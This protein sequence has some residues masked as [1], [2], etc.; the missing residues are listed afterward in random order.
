MPIKTY[1]CKESTSAN[2]LDER[3]SEFRVQLGPELKKILV[4]IFIGPWLSL[5]T[6]RF[7]LFFVLL[8]FSPCPLGHSI[9]YGVEFL[10][11]STSKHF[12]IPLR[13]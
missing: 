3:G 5:P 12:Q 1:F 6:Q 11:K 10:R 13:R 9:Q 4:D 8:N 7:F 2:H